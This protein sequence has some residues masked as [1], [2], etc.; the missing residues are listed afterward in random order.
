M[1]TNMLNI[2]ENE[3][4]YDFQTNED[5]LFPSMVVVTVTNVCNLR[6]IHCAYRTV[7][8]EPDYTPHFLETN[9]FKKAVDEISNHKNSFL[10]IS[11]DGEPLL[12]KQ[13]ADMILYAKERKLFPVTVNTNGI[14]LTDNIAKKLLDA[15][16]DMIEISINAVESKVYEEM[17]V[18]GDYNKLISNIENLISLRSKGNY[19]TKIW[20]STIAFPDAPEDTK[21]FNQL[22]KNKADE[23]IIRPFFDHQGL[24]KNIEGAGHHIKPRF[25]CPKLWKRITLD[26]SGWLK[27]CEND[28]LNKSLL[29]DYR[30]DITIEKLWQT[31]LYS[32]LR[33]YHFNGNYNKIPVCDTCNDWEVM[34]W[35]YDYSAA[36]KKLFPD[37]T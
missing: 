23:I 10:R 1:A 32:R 30:S 7:I 15:G 13:F 20:V 36:I 29:A 26:S 18:N 9:L 35:N 34:D 24:V 8:K 3:I 22:W 37:K 12:H 31:E 5:K 28:W 16:I 19:K 21:T 6:C 4:Q 2:N 27:F 17:R 25:P 11:G 33:D 14:L